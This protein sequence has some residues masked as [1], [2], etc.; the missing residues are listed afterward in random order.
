MN[1]KKEAERIYFMDI[2]VKEKIR[3]LEQN[4]ADCYEEMAAVEQ[5]MHPEISHEA[6]EGLRKT[7]DYLDQLKKKL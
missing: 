1:L 2:S 7:N 5:N 3:L 6:D 4:A